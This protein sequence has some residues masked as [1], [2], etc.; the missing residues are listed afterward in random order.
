[1]QLTPVL[2]VE[3]GTL[4]QRFSQAKKKMLNLMS[5]MLLSVHNNPK[6]SSTC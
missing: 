2:W 5:I 4:A 3:T 1:M 6:R